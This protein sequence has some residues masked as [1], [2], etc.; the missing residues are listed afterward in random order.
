VLL[1]S[2]QVQ[3]LLQ[4]I[5]NRIALLIPT[6]GLATKLKWITG[7]V[8][9]LINLSVF[10]IWVPARLQINDTFIHV[11]EIWDRIEKVIFALFDIGLNGY[12]LYLT[13]TR[14][15]NK[16]LT[17]YN[18]LFKVNIIMVFLSLSLDVILIGTMSMKSSLLYLN[19]HPVAYLLKLY[20]E[21]NMADLIV[22]VVRA[23]NPH[24]HVDGSYSHEKSSTGIPGTHTGGIQSTTAAT[25]ITA[26]KRVSRPRN[27]TVLDGD[28][29]EDLEL[30]GIQKTTETQVVFS[31]KSL[32]DDDGDSRSSSTRELRQPFP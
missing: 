31:S 4:I 25:T 8:L 12:F 15:I 9:A 28:S 32:E 29:T 19:F 24:A 18:R 16:G 1:W 26:S 11:N 10:C 2:I 5:I 6:R 22:K 20:I 23:T 17:K 3:L 13:R 7:L 21:M 14:L 27:G 30:A